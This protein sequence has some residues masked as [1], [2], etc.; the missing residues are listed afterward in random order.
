[1]QDGF[2]ADCTAIKDKANHAIE[3]LIA[4]A[5]HTPLSDAEIERVMNDPVEL[6]PKDQAAIDSWDIEKIMDVITRL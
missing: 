5:F 3:G 4:L 6:S 1:L 2:C